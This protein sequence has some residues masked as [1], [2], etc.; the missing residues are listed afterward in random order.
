VALP[1]YTLSKDNRIGYISIIDLQEKSI[2]DY[3]EY[4]A[5]NSFDVEIAWSPDSEWIAVIPHNVA[6]AEDG[7]LWIFGILEKSKHHFT[8]ASFI[9]GWDS[10]S[11]NIYYNSKDAF[12]S[13]NIK[14]WEKKLERS[15]Y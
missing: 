11:S 12:I 15:C 7:G 3:L 6:Y 14:T 4:S 8:N 5:I 1:L 10:E 13:I 9:D 2:E